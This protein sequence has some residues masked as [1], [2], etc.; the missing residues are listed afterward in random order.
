MFST[1][2]IF[3]QQEN[4]VDNQKCQA[5]FRPICNKILFLVLFAPPPLLEQHWFI[6]FCIAIKKFSIKKM[7]CVFA[8]AY[9]CIHACIQPVLKISY[10]TD[11]YK[12]K[13]IKSEYR[14][15]FSQGRKLKLD[16]D[17]EHST[18][19]LTSMELF[20]TVLTYIS[21]GRGEKWTKYIR[22]SWWE[23]SVDFIIRK[24]LNQS[25]TF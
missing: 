24:A 13:R 6:D 21:L 19:L 4:L 12:L 25:Q 15:F 1:D 20:P 10:S 3:R 7:D 11:F 18:Y 2:F 22:Q 8:S 23:S 16:E 14:L 5:G 9:I 17:I